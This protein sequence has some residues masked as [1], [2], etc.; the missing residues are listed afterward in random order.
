MFLSMSLSFLVCYVGILLLGSF[1]DG[2][3]S[4]HASQIFEDLLAK[5]IDTGKHR[6]RKTKILL[7][8][9]LLAISFFTVGAQ[10]SQPEKNLHTIEQQLKEKQ[11]EYQQITRREKN[12]LAE[13]TEIDHELQTYQQELQK[14]RELLQEKT[15]NSQDREKSIQTPQDFTTEENVIGQT[16]ACDL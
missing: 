3:Q 10:H 2:A 14:H 13:L 16:I 4:V 12:L 5:M 8:W 7:C 11:T 6:N 15:L 1:L 9:G